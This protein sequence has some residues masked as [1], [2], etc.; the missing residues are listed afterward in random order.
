MKLKDIIIF[1]L[2]SAL[3]VVSI[4]TAVFIFKQC[5]LLGAL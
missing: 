2:L 1:G 4:I 3:L 5:Q